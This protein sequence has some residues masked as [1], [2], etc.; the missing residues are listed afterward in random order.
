MKCLYQE[1]SSHR[2]IHRP[3]LAVM[4]PARVVK[5]TVISFED[6]S[7]WM[8]GHRPK[9]WLWIVG[10]TIGLILN[11]NHVWHLPQREAVKG[12]PTKWHRVRAIMGLW[13]GLEPR[14]NN[15]GWDHKQPYNW[16]RHGLPR[17]SKVVHTGLGMN[18]K[19]WLTTKKGHI[20][21]DHMIRS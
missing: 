10:K 7:L 19:T 21:L 5:Q 2:V 8:S 11:S 14:R 17:P 9:G 15:T 3:H 6:D 4:E 20:K 1:M 18:N 12:T 16:Q 13:L